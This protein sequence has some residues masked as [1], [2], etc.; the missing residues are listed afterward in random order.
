LRY[1]NGYTSFPKLADD[2]HFQV[3]MR[4]AAL[5]T[6]KKLWGRN[7]VDTMSSGTYSIE[8]LMSELEMGHGYHRPT[9]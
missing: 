1:P 6:F 5:P 4:T 9:S 7:D 2:E 3:W 8:I